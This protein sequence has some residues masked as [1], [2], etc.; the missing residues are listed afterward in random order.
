M[1]KQKRKRSTKEMKN[2]FFVHEILISFFIMRANIGHKN[3]G[4]I[5]KNKNE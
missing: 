5:T 1:R 4:T 3:C 2:F